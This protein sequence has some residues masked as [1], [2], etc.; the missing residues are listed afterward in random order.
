MLLPCLGRLFQTDA[1]IQRLHNSGS[2]MNRYKFGRCSRQHPAQAPSS[3]S[4]YR[5]L[6]KRKNASTDKVGISSFAHSPLCRIPWDFGS[7]WY[8]SISLSDKGQSPVKSRHRVKQVPSTCF[9]QLQER[10]LSV[11]VR[12]RQFLSVNGSF[13]PFPSVSVRFLRRR[14]RMFLPW[15]ARFSAAAA[16][17]FYATPF[18]WVSFRRVCTIC[19]VSSHSHPP[20]GPALT[21][22]LISFGIFVLLF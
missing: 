17:F 15:I 7:V 2:P 22:A 19:W 10:V 20:R 4:A 16:S 13:C 6:C 14:Y 21:L 8:S 5:C 3:D 9:M 12:L 11:S 1:V 18:C